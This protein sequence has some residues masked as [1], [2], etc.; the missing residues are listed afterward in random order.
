MKKILDPHF[1]HWSPRALTFLTG[2]LHLA[3]LY[4]VSHCSLT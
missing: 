4:I 3:H 2:S 1:S